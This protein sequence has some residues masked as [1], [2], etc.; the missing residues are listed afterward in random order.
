MKI[1]Y[2]NP[3]ATRA[4]TDGIVATARAALPGAEITGMTNADGPAAIEGAADGDAAVPG[5]LT[6]LEAAQAAGADAV[7]IACFDDTGLAEAQARAACPVLGIGQAS[8]VMA[9]LLGR[10]FSVV[11]SLPVSIPV[12]EE[13]IARQGFAQNCVSVRAS[14]LP[15]LTIDAGAP[16]TLDRIAATIEATAREDGAACAVLGCAGMAPLKPALETRTR[17]PLI[18]GVAASA[19]LARAAVEAKRGVGIRAP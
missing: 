8:F 14:G 6:R 10:R 3:N 7:V 18:D 15:V 11:T 12:I 16:E 19:L 1:V 4:M 5:M 2:I 17:V 13:N 9:A